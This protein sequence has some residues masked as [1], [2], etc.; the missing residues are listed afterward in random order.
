MECE[1]E[2]IY[3]TDI[4]NLKE[5]LDAPEPSGSVSDRSDECENDSDEETVGDERSEN[6]LSRPWIELD[7]IEVNRDKPSTR[8]CRSLGSTCYD[9]LQL[10]EKHLLDLLEK[11]RKKIKDLQNQI[12]SL[13][14]PSDKTMTRGSWYYMFGIPYFK[15][16]QYFPCP[17]NE[18]H[19]EKT[20]MELSVVD[21][22][23]LRQWKKKDKAK[24]EEAIKE[25]EVANHVK[26]ATIR[27]T[28]ILK[29]LHNTT[30]SAKIE[31]LESEMK[32]CNPDKIKCKT[33]AQLVGSNKSEYDWMKISAVDLEGYHSPD[34]CRAMWHNYL[35]PMIRKS[36]WTKDEDSKL[37]ELVDK[38]NNQNWDAIA[39]ELGTKR[40]G[41]QC[42]C[43]YQT[44]LNDKL[45][46]SK[47]TEEEDAYLIEVINKC[48]IG[49][50]IPW[51]K[52]TFYMS[53]R[54]KNQ[55]FNRWV[56]SLDP[57]I[58]KGRFTKN[59][60]MLVVAAVRRYGTD[61]PR[62]ARF[63]PGRTSI[64]VRDRYHSLKN[65][66]TGEPWTPDEDKLLLKLV[67]ECGEGNWSKIF[68][69]F[70]NRTRT[71]VR[72]RYSTL[73]SWMKKIPLETENMNSAP[74]RRLSIENNK[75]EK[76]WH[77]VQTVL[78]SMK[79]CSEVN[80]NSLLKLKQ[81]LKLEQKKRPGRKVGQKKMLSI[82]DKQYY[83]FFRCVYT[84][85][86]GRKKRRYDADIVH[87]NS[88]VV[89]SMLKHFQ[90][91][92]NIPRYDV[93]QEDNLLLESD[94]F[95][96]HYLRDR[97]SEN[98]NSQS[99]GGNESTENV[100]SGDGVAVSS[101]STRIP[102]LCPPNHT[103]LVGFRTLLL[104]RRNLSAN[105]NVSEA[106]F[107][108]VSDNESSGGCSEKM[109]TPEQA[110]ALWQERLASLFV[111]PALLSNTLPKLIVPVFKDDDVPHPGSSEEHTTSDN[112]CD[113]VIG[114][115][116]R[117]PK[118]KRGRKRKTNLK[119]KKISESPPKK[120]RKYER[121]GKFK[122][123]IEPREH[124]VIRRSTRHSSDL[125]DVHRS[126]DIKTEL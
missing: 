55:V 95:I 87:S 89:D 54:S 79:S 105:V 76:V 21:L 45:R 72:H 60:D 41:Y 82:I 20:N 52:V 29:A 106:R 53:G 48:R 39:Q 61:F 116:V 31:E 102:Y 62:V 17:P 65:P 86:G 64:Q 85:F 37:K 49:S 97:Q 1:S 110:K 114:K 33:L 2:D 83:S 100:S 13:K 80:E 59:E 98:A 14:N 57:S 108:A 90:A 15:D 36:K 6:D 16:R 46:K 124:E 126:E 27:R 109:I 51:A 12:D 92:I 18:D 43:Q 35:H 58:K 23:P 3:F 70:A 71:Q 119:K 101:A 50:Y 75:E 122:R 47:W 30:D 66:G 104:S 77:R 96:L 28:G 74:T 63:L 123:P 38:Y 22:P 44:R 84:Q 115:A 11:C 93:V 68:R 88:Q 25:E 103:T 113:A 73:Q 4:A 117:K 19:T 112:S 91:N 32:D 94:K 5:V 99:D 24:L 67:E 40:S 42:M 8:V 10:T 34:E 120:K 107:D 26:E 69:H 9:V 81:R 121:T 118:P 78:R 111:W 7:E 56:Y 125:S